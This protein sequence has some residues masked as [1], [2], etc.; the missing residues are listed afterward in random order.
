MCLQLVCSLKENHST[1][2]V[3]GGRTVEA[4]P[5]GQ[6]CH[7]QPWDTL[8]SGHRTEQ[9][10]WPHNRTHTQPSS[11]LIPHV[12]AHVEVRWQGR[13][14]LTMWHIYMATFQQGQGHTFLY[15]TVIRSHVIAQAESMGTALSE[16]LWLWQIHCCSYKHTTYHPWG[17]VQGFLL[18]LTIWLIVN[19]LHTGRMLVGHPKSLIITTSCL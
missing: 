19:I 7:L 16:Q 10:A 11:W 13:W 4:H 14:I 6:L 2:K 8:C 3:H 1:R 18:F 12:P 5:P 15:D 9:T 17:S